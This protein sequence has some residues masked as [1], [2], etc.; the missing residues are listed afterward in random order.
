[1]PSITATGSAIQWSA[2]YELGLKQVDL[3]HKALVQMLGDAWQALVRNDREKALQLV[4]R[5]E[6][7]TT[8][9]FA[10][11]EAFM[12]KIGYPE[13]AAHKERHDAFVQRIA[14]ERAAMASGTDISLDLFHFLRDWLVQHIRAEDRKYAAFEARQPSSPSLLSSFFRLFRA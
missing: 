5:L 7:Y 4:Q 3:Q 1:M 12:R 14:R 6:D 13:F 10:E 2:D 9:H 8:V 11:E